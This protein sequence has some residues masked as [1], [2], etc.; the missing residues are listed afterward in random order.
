MSVVLP[1]ATLLNPPKMVWF[2]DNGPTPLNP[3][4]RQVEI[5][6]VNDWLDVFNRQNG[7]QCVPRFNTLYSTQY[8]LY[9]VLGRPTG[10]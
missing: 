9:W 5:V 8:S 10:S 2:E 1:V 6:L 7:R 3:F 4:D